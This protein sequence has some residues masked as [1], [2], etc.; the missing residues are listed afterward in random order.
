MLV[1]EGVLSTLPCCVIVLTSDIDIAHT[2]PIK[3]ALRAVQ[4]HSAQYENIS[5]ALLALAVR[6]FP[7]LFVV[8]Q[9]LGQDLAE[10][11]AT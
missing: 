3:S 1:Y 10:S 9:L 4:A 5:A 6:N 2:L 11:E 8:S 7:Q